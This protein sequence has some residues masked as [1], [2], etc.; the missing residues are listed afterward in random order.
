VRTQA[1]FRASFAEPLS[2]TFT[3]AR[4]GRRAAVHADALGVISLRD[5]HRGEWRLGRKRHLRVASIRNAETDRCTTMEGGAL[6]ATIN[7]R[8]SKRMPDLRLIMVLYSRSRHASVAPLRAPSAH[9]EAGWGDASGH[10]ARDVEPDFFH[11]AIIF[12]GTLG[13][14]GFSANISG[15]AVECITEPKYDPPEGR[16]WYYHIDRATDRKCWYLMALAPETPPATAA[17]SQRASA[18]SP[19]SQTLS[20]SDQAAL[21]LEFLRWKEQQRAEQ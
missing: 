4:L 5:A 9:V 10:G 11:V 20:E 3:A 18:R 8:F 1:P 17:L 13:A 7:P 15:A 16:H 12:L 2:Q 19:L 21:Y 14:L 6:I